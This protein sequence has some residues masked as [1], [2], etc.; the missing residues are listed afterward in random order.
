MTLKKRSDNRGF[1]ELRPIT[2]KVG[3]IE[4][5]D[6]SAMFQL[7]KTI[8]Y[9]AVYGPRQLYPQFLQ[10][11]ERGK[12][13]CYYNMLAFSGAGERVR[14][15]PSRRSKEIGLVTAN[16]LSSVLDLSEFP[17]SV[18]DVF[19][20]LVQTDAGTRCAGIC[21]AALALADA[22]FPMKDMVTAVGIGNLNGQILVDMSKEEEDIEGIADIPVAMLPNSGKITLLQCDGYIKKEE[23]KEIFKVAKKACT[24]IYNIQ[25]KALLERYTKWA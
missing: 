19:I 3:I 7:G 18:V 11:P 1:D 8:A 23:L 22:G 10:N 16:A 24:E 5:A 9:A 17:N 25:K 20:E 21:A 15:G 13:R 14:P 12:L 6:G 2:A 4:R